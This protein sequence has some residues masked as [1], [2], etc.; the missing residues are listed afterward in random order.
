MQAGRSDATEA[1]SSSV[2][3]QEGIRERLSDILIGRD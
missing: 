3:L 2:G 1:A